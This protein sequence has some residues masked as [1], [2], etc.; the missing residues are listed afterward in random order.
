[1]SRR[2]V[3]MLSGS[4]TRGL[5]SMILP[6]MIS[7]VM[8][9][10]FSAIDMTVLKRYSN[11]LAVGAVG[12]CSNLIS[13]S[14]ALLLGISIGS[15]MVVA[16]RLGS[17]DKA[18][19]ERA[20]VTAVK[21]AVIGGLLL[22]GLG[23]VFAETFLR[24]T[25]CHE[26]LLPQATTYLRLYFCAV[27]MLMVYNFCA[28]I[29]RAT[30]DTRRPMYFLLLNGVIKVIL[31]FIFVARL[32][33]GVASVAVA[34]IIASSVSCT[35]AIVTLIRFQ[36][37]VPVRILKTRFD[38]VEFKA[39]ISIGIPAGLQS[40]LLAFANVAITATANSFGADATTG[41]AIANQFENILYHIT[42]APAVAVAP[43]VSQNIGAGNLPRVKRTVLCGVLITV[44]CSATLGALSAIFSGQLAGIMSDS[45]TII[46]FAKQKMII[47]SIPYFMAGLYE[48]FGGVLR[49]IGK[50]IVP[51]VTSLLFICLL[52]FAWVYAAFPLYPNLGFLYLVWPIGW[53]LSLIVHFVIYK[54]QMGKLQKQAS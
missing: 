10:V 34:T 37:V 14:T 26:S 22:M 4:V 11:D 16:R 6:I 51:T 50:P 40:G 45:P 52:R 23:V 12:A 30:G 39:M 13:L 25:N 38:F 8:Q 41:V 7:N 35:L 47:T 3:N 53:L 42:A 20:A 29:L 1:M 36:Q 17:G 21:S 49:S 9:S 28:S 43:Y 32:D 48:L 5:I 27:P 31:N 24:W 2:N 19:A 33:M 44:V 15:N 54:R 46:G 18:A